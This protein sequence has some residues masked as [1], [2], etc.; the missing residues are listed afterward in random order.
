MAKR[1]AL[2]KI[3]D[4]LPDIDQV[5]TPVV[6]GEINEVILRRQKVKELSRMGFDTR[7]MSMILNRGIKGGDGK[8]IKVAC[9]EATIKHDLNRIAQESLAEDKSYL[10]KRMEVLDKLGYLYHQAMLEFRDARTPGVKNSFLNTAM[11]ILGKNTDIEGIASPQKFDIAASSETQS[12]SAAQEIRNLDKED[13]DAII[14]TITNVL[15][16]SGESQEPVR[17]FL[18]PEAPRVPASSSNDEGIS[19]K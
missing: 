9:S 7:R 10:E 13:Q 17:S 19:G 4:T 5:T 8:T 11:A 12:F 2:E 15:E 18:L 14:S 1:S 16:R 3:G 6:E